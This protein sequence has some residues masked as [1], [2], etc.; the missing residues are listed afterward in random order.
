MGKLAACGRE[1]GKIVARCREAGELAG[2]C[3]EPR[4]EAGP[5]SLRPGSKRF[6]QAEGELVACCR[7]A[8]SMLPGGWESL[9]TRQGGGKIV[10]RRALGPGGGACCALLGGGGACGREAGDFFAA[11]GRMLERLWKVPGCGGACGALPGGGGG[12]GREAGDFFGRR[13]SLRLQCGMLQESFQHAAAGWE[14]LRTRQGGGKACGA[15]PGLGE[16]GPSGGVCAA[17]PGCGGACGREAEFFFSRHAAGRQERCSVLQGGW[18]IISTN[19]VITRLLA[20]ERLS[21]VS[22]H[23]S[24]GGRGVGVVAGSIGVRQLG[25]L[26]LREKEVRVFLS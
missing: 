10:A 11:R 20:P 17:L 21:S 15:L 1:A 22:M 26:T 16:A 9:R 2:R 25:L 5:G 24:G 23:R 6:F 3:R 19:R 14:I 18:S 13:E 4:V 7:R 8:F 12:C